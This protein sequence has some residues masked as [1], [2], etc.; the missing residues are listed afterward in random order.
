MAQRRLRQHT[1]VLRCRFHLSILESRKLISNSLCYA[2]NQA[3]QIRGGSLTAV[4]RR[5]QGL[6]AARNNFPVNEQ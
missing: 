5:R 4:G 1:H 6:S 2:L 3:S